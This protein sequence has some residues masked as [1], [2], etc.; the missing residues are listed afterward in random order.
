MRK[1]KN[2]E[3]DKQ[4]SGIDKNEKE[5]MDS[6]KAELNVLREE[7]AAKDDYY[8][9]FIRLQAEFDNFRKRAVKEK[10]EFIKFANEALILELVSILDDFERSIRSAEHKK[11]FDLLHQGVDIISKQLHRLLEEKGLNKIKSVGEKF[12]PHEHEAI[13]VV[14]GEDNEDNTILEELQP[15]YIL[16]GRI[17]RPAKVKVA[18]NSS[19]FTVD[20]SQDDKEQKK[21][22]KE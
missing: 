8:D 2:M 5:E 1:D 20:S 6:L 21:E 12:N 7:I 19:Q 10:G 3:E 15:G 11:D 14:E 22:E 17:I 18:K 16:N 9:K 13:E 4:P